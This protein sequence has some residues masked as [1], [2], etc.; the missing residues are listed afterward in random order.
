M[1]PKHMPRFEIWLA[2]GFVVLFIIDIIFVTVTVFF[3][4]PT[5]ETELDIIQSIIENI[6]L[7]QADIE[8]LGYTVSVL[9]AKQKP[10]NKALRRY[11]LNHCQH[12]TLVLTNVNN[13]MYCFYYGFDGCISTKTYPATVKRGYD[14]EDV[15]KTVRLEL[16][17][18]NI[19]QAPLLENPNEIGESAYYDIDV[20][21]DVTTFSP[22]EGK[23][24]STWD[25]GY[26]STYYCSNNFVDH[27]RF[28]G[29][30]PKENS[31]AE[32]RCIKK[33][34]DAAELLAFYRQGI[35]LQERLFQLYHANTQ[36]S[37]DVS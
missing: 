33:E 32:D 27:M 14:Y 5:E 20:S 1:K 12:P 25:S 13:E 11:Y 26:Y 23:E 37:S 17:K 19:Y 15:L 24:V 30:D 31:R 28:N 29:L 9:P 36:E 3:P 34:Y 16:Y 4:K 2:I 10:E 21:T 7:Y 6:E 22:A 35:A 18:R 8:A